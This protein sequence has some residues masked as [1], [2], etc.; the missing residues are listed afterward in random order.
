MKKSKVCPWWM[1][2]MLLF[3]L[4]KIGQDPKKILSPYIKPGMSIMDYGCAMGYFSIPLAR[5]TGRKGHVYCV[6]IQKKML[7][8]LKKRSVK[9]N[10]TS[11]IRPLQVGINYHPA[12]LS[13][14][15]DFILL[16]AVVHEVPDKEKLFRDL[17]KMSKSGCKVLLA[18]PKSHVTTR[19]FTKSLLLAQSAGYKVIDEKPLQNGLCTLLM[20]PK[21]VEPFEMTSRFN[22]KDAFQDQPEIS[23]EQ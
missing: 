10:V 22:K 4:R 14:Q 8:K 5:M 12:D 17:Y 3:P 11:I 18:E 2:Y 19:N 9:Y 23:I 15:L 13:G 16:F 6:D 20:K 21:V 1:G 7:E